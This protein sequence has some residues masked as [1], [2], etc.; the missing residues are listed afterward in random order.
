MLSLTSTLL[1]SIGNCP[2]M[3]QDY[4]NEGYGYNDSDED[5]EEDEENEE[6]EA[7]KGINRRDTRKVTMYVFRRQ[8]L[9]SSTLKHSCRTQSTPFVIS[10]SISHVPASTGSFRGVP[11]PSYS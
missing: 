10:S 2:T 5:E 7:Q 1:Q 6:A 4:K 3:I 9:S 11:S 8:K